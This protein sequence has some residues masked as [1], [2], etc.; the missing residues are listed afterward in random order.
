MASWA[1]KS[2]ECGGEKEAEIKIPKGGFL[3]R[4]NIYSFIL[5]K[6]KWNK[7]QTLPVLGIEVF[8]E[9]NYYD[10]SQES[11]ILSTRD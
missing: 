11:I 9:K 1:A 7:Y 8:K 6:I 4:L 5:E 3:C 10:I 2:Q